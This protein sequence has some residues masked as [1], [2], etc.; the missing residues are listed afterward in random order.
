MRTETPEALSAIEDRLRHLL[1]SPPPNPQFGLWQQTSQGQI[2][3]LF[4]TSVGYA[5]LTDGEPGW[6]YYVQAELDQRILPEDT[7]TPV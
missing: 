7:I 5:H 1:N 2:V 4:W 6:Y 3:G